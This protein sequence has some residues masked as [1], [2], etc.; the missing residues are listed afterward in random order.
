VARAARGGAGGAAPLTPPLAAPLALGALLSAAAAALLAPLPDLLLDALVALSWAASVA[1]LVAVA[2]CDSPLALGRFPLWVMLFTVGRLCLNVATTR[3]I[4]TDARAGD[5]VAGVGAQVMGDR[6]AVGVVFVAALLLIQLVVLARGAE[7]VAQVT[8]R[9]AL[10]ALPGA[11]QA[12]TV[13]VEAGLLHP[14]EARRARERLQARAELCG[15]LDGAMRFVQGDAVASLALV[16]VNAAGGVAV[17]ALHGGLSLQ[18]AWARYAPLTV[19]DAL[20]AQLPALLGAVA[21]GAFVSRLPSAEGAPRAARGLAGAALA[22]AALLGAAGACLALAL[23]PW[24][25]WGARAAWLAVGAAALAA[26][27]AAAPRQAGAAAPAL[28]LT[29]HPEALAAAGGARALGAALEAAG[30][31]RGLP[32]RALALELSEG[33]L[34]RGGYRLRLGARAL[35]EGAVVRGA[36]LSLSAPP[37]GAV[38]IE[39]RHPRWGLR[40]WWRPEGEGLSAAVER[41]ACSALEALCGRCVGA[42]AAGGDAAWSVEEAWGWASAAPEPLK[43]CALTRDLSPL[44]LT[45]AARALSA[46]G[47]DLRDPR[48]LLEALG[49]LGAAAPPAALARA[50][51][52]RAAEEGAGA[53]PYVLVELPLSAEGASPAEE[54]G[55]GAWARVEGALR[56]AALSESSWVVL[57]AAAQR[58]D[59]ARRLAARG[60]WAEVWAWEDVPA[61]RPLRLVAWAG[62]A[63]GP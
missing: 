38:V 40:G 19:G 35:C 23:A 17:G 11:Q 47:H 22:R 56:A 50:L 16:G 37:E 41:G 54:W 31:A 33:A 13:A 21:V 15:A 61:G 2:R 49:A 57:C 52:Q 43:G 45:L 24:W 26:A 10:D 5:V 25:A 60:L 48:P 27:L 4:L 6:W 59:L 58:A 9:F 7:R 18:A 1:L 3:A 14:E 51:R 8:A 36:Y 55:E 29:L 62:A 39:G 44:A 42:W 46:E 20:T 53:L 34:P 32:A 28:T 63:E 30:R 12:L